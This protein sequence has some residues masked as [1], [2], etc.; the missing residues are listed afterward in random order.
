M[1][2][3]PVD[4]GIP[5][6]CFE[7]TGILIERQAL[8]FTPAAVPVTECVI[9]HRSEQV[10]AGVVRRVG[11]EAQAIAL[12]ETARLL[13]AVAPGTALRLTGFIS[14]KSQ[15]SRQL[16]LHITT[17]TFVEGNLNG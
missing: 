4:D 2:R 5:L 7:L 16:R 10:E 1:S 12:G 9:G 13:Q 15:K 3:T 17:I 6:N 11:F 8:R 14:A